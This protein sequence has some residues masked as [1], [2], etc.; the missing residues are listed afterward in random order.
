MTKNQPEVIKF[1]AQ[2][3]QVKTLIDGGANV[4]LSLSGKELKALTQ[5]LQ[6]KQ[7]IGVLLEVVAVPVKPIIEAP[8]KNDTT[9]RKERYPYKSK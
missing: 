4:T 1:Q 7:Q 3:W 8:K 6:V 5:L 2:V 9:R